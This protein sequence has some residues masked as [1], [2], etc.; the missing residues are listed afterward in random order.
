MLKRYV[1]FPAIWITVLVLWALPAL[2]EVI[3][4]TAWVR[5]YDGPAN[6]GDGATALAVDDSG[7][8]YVTGDSW[9]MTSGACATIK[10]YPDGD[11]A[12]VRRYNGPENEGVTPAAIALSRFG[13]VFVTGSFYEPPQDCFT[14]KYNASGDTAWVRRYNGPA[15]SIDETYAIAVDD[16]DNVYVT[17]RTGSNSYD[18]LTIKYYPNG[19]TA[20]VRRYDGPAHL[21]DLAY[22]LAI[23]D[24][25][26]VYVTGYS[27]GSGCITIKYKPNGETAWVRIYNLGIGEALA[28]DTHGN[29]YVTGIYFTPPGNTD[30]LT[31]KYDPSGTLLWERTY[32]GEGNW[33][34]EP[35]AIALDDSG[36]VYVTGRSFGNQTSFDWAA[37]KYFPDGDTAWVRRYNGPEDS[38]D[39]AH[40]LCVDKS[41]NV[42]VTGE[43]WKSAGGRSTQSDYVTIKYDQT[44]NQVWLREFDG[45]ASDWDYASAIVVDKSNN[46]YVTGCSEGLGTQGDYATIK[47]WQNYPPNFFSL[48]SPPDS[49]LIPHV[50]ALDWE[51][52]VDPDITD[53]TTYDLYISTSSVF[54]PDSTIIHD[55]L[56][57]SQYTDT[58]DI[59]R[60]YW[61]V[62]AFD[63]HSA[64]RW[65]DETW[66]FDVFL[67]GDANGDG[68]INIADVVYLIN[69]LFID[70]PAPVPIQAGDV[71]CSD[72]ITAADVVYLINYLFIGGPPPCEP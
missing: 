66:A 21:Y 25:G 36:N 37:I 14:I 48:L 53:T 56:S 72:Y 1:F 20:W 9:G 71:N 63:D 31:L 51:T 29:I 8:V 61:K 44:G 35:E 16:S 59:G 39:Y 13:D 52:A 55:S 30:Y 45:P 68:V 62:W 67:R 2:A 7:N 58:L 47:Y 69:F 23:D 4:D 49:S 10:Y 33:I 11:T 41:G 6:D 60:Y 24:S 54:N 12:W 28:V 3:V 70:G 64:G 34:D 26:Y 27:E 18:C 5:R 65:S 57:I 17:G 46:V 22:D 38:T 40:S 43:S 42:Y 50:V 32:N 19:D 15:N